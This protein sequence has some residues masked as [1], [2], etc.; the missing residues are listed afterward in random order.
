[1][2]KRGKNTEGHVKHALKKGNSRFVLI[3]NLDVSN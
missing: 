1:M 2:L 3:P